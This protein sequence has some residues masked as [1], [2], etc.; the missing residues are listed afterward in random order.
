MDYLCTIADAAYITGVNASTIRRW[1]SEHKLNQ[2][3]PK[4]HL[5]NLADVEHLRDTLKRQAHD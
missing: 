5:I 3:G 4:P 1:I 2:H